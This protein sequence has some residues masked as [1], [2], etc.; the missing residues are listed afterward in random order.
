MLIKYFFYY[1]NCRYIKFIHRFE[2]SNIF[3]SPINHPR[4]IFD[5]RK[6]IKRK[7]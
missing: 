3:L 6:K 7:F 1:F 5:I 2:I 4:I